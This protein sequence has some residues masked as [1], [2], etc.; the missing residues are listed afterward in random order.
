MYVIAAVVVPELALTAAVIAEPEIAVLVKP[1]LAVV[2]TLSVGDHF[3]ACT[4][5]RAIEAPQIDDAFLLAE[6][7]E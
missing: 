2:D 5:M 3:V 4:T 7:P 6:S 1:V